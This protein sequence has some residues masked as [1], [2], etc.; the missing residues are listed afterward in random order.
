MPLPRTDAYL[1][2]IGEHVED[3]SRIAAT[4]PFRTHGPALTRDALAFLATESARARRG[5]TARDPSLVESLTA[6]EMTTDEGQ[7][8]EAGMTVAGLLTEPRARLRMESGRGSTPLTF[9]AY[10]DSGRA[11]VVA[12]PSPAGF[13][14]AP[15]GDAIL[16][17][18]TTVH[19]DLCDV[20]HVPLAMAGWVGLAPAWSLA[21]TP[22]LLGEELILRRADDPAVPPPDDADAN[23]RYMW[24]QPWFLWT[25]QA[26]GV[27]HGRVMVNAGRAGHFAL[28]QGEDERVRFGA[29]P[30]YDV[31]FD[32]VAMVERSVSAT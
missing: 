19:L 10:I 17:A 18:A 1:E 28:M 32:L 23:L 16:T 27:D 2:S 8:T 13:E 3:V 9:D 30:S 11:L 31:W 29:M 26:S 24:S 14:E 12:N 22:E 25:L 4:Q 6:A 15:H 21:T 5:A 20:T 7:L